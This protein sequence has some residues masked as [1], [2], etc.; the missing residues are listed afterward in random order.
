MWWA[1][2]NL[3]RCVDCPN[4][5]R[6]H[7]AHLKLFVV[8][9]LVPIASRNSRPSIR[10]HHSCF[11]SRT[12]SVGFRSLRPTNYHVSCPFGLAPSEKQFPSH[13]SPL[14]LERGEGENDWVRECDGW[15]QQADIAFGGVRNAPHSN[16]C[17]TQ[18]NAALSTPYAPPI[19]PA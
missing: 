11:A 18:S 1:N 15:P 14:H 3:V 13:R 17:S 4:A 6:W 5:H 8:L 7:N 9:S 19:R 16:A 2:C 12:S 10:V